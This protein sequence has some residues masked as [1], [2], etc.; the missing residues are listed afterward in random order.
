MYRNFIG[1]L[2]YIVN[3][4]RPDISFPVNYLTIHAL[5]VLKFLC[6]TRSLKLNYNGSFDKVMDAYVDADSAAY[7]IDRKDFDSGF[8]GNAV[9]WKSQKQNIVS[10]ASTHTEYY[11]LAPAGSGFQHWGRYCPNPASVI[12]AEIPLRW[13]NNGERGAMAREHRPGCTCSDRKIYLRPVAPSWFE[14]RSE[15]GSKIDTQNCCIIRVQSWT[16]DRDYVH[17]E[18]LK[19]AVRNLDPRLT[20]IVEKPKFASYLIS[21][22]HFGTKTDES[23]IQIHEISLVQHFYVGTKIKED[24]GSGLGSF[25]LGSGKMLVQPG[26]SGTYLWRIFATR[27]L[28]Q[29]ENP[30]KVTKSRS[31]SRISVPAKPCNMHCC[32]VRLTSEPSCLHACLQWWRCRWNEDYR[33]NPLRQGNLF[34][35]KRARVSTKRS[36]NSS[37]A[38]VEMSYRV[39]ANSTGP[40]LFQSSES[41]RGVPPTFWTRVDEMRSADVLSRHGRISAL[42]RG[43]FLTQSSNSLLIFSGRIHKH[44]VQSLDPLRHRGGILTIPAKLAKENILPRNARSGINALYAE[45]PTLCHKSQ[46]AK[47][48]CGLPRCGRCIFNGS[49]AT[50]QLGRWRSSPRL[51]RARQSSARLRGCSEVI[52]SGLTNVPEDAHQASC[53]YVGHKWQIA[54]PQVAYQKVANDMW[55]SYGRQE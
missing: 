1:A 26:L 6:H 44:R 22:S 13:T 18:L 14:T 30:Y 55:F 34:Y 45:R 2:L 25:D 23:E 16:G 10:R 27:S 15:I 52:D 33:Q 40:R 41:T 43:H 48:R 24:H 39:A 50:G 3:G 29:H 54:G 35:D 21:I 11:A 19:L 8:F 42:V 4:T 37:T 36:Q 51:G 12:A 9:I 17:F 20:T 31:V 49:C 5:R 53:V 38:M 46:L 28:Y 32:T 47:N 7:I